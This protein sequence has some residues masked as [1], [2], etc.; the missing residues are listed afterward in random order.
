MCLTATSAYATEETGGHDIPAW[1]E[2]SEMQ[3]HGLFL[4]FAG[5][6]VEASAFK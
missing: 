4:M 6:E 2:G 1:E 3:N 5:A